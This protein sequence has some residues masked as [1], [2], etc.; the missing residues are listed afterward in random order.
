MLDE[1]NKRTGPESSDRGH[2]ASRNWQ[3]CL[4][5][6]RSVVTAGIPLPPPY[7]DTGQARLWDHLICSET[8]VEGPSVSVT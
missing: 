7:P 2:R 4:A 6:K 3:E 1:S 5:A 8:T